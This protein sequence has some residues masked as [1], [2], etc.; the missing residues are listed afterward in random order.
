MTTML[1]KWLNRSPYRQWWERRS[2]PT[3]VTIQEQY[4]PSVLA[5][6]LKSLHTPVTRWRKP[7]EYAQS[8]VALGKGTDGG[9]KNRREYAE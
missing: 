1:Y 6:E 8:Y 2:L 4:L 3:L 5:Q 9:K 7:I